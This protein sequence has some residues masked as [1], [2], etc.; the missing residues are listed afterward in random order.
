MTLRGVNLS[1]SKLTTYSL[2]GGMLD[3]PR[4]RE[5]F[6]LLAR[7]W[8]ISCGVQSTLSI[9]VNPARKGTDACSRTPRI[10][11]RR[12]SAEE[13]QDC[14]GEDQTGQRNECADPLGLTAA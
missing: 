10:G 3:D 7:C 2:M 6:L 12:I 14:P 1:G 5:E 4:T 8:L 13:R 9:P 11:A